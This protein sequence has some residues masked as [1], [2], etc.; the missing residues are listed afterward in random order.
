MNYLEKI[1]KARIQLILE[2]PFFATLCMRIAFTPDN[3]IKTAITNGKIVQYNPSFID[4]LSV[5]ELKGVI[6]HE[7]M[8]I[9]MLHH[10]R[11]NN[12]DKKLWNKACDYAIN[13]MV[14]ASNFSMPEGYLINPL[15]DNT[16][17]EQIYCFLQQAVNDGTHADD[18]AGNDHSTGDVE[19]A[20]PDV[21]TQEIEAEVKQAV[22]QASMIAKRQGKLPDHI[23]RLIDAILQPKIAW[24]DVLSRFLAEITRNDYSWK[25]PS[26]R[27][28][29]MGIYLP[30]LQNLEPGKIILIVDTSM[31]ID[32]DLINQFA[33]EVQDITNTFNLSLTVM[34]VD[35][36]VRAVQEIEPDTPIQ[37]KPKGGGGTDFRPGFQYIDQQELHPKVVIYLTDGECKSLPSVPEYPVLWAQF[38]DYDFKPPFGEVLQVQ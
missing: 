6:A 1:K 32:Q 2:Q 29:S 26:N 33:T 36:K 14:V 23:E 35:T 9:I 12:R 22:V 37:L 21:S 3:S 15:Y 20:P 27:Y 24:Q 31:S 19:D 5:E 17:A 16:S 10:T 13:P 18:D 28:L 30:S 4:E 11:R 8:H 7:I 25:N 34:Y 38:G